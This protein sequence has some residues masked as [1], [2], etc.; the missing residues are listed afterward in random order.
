MSTTPQDLESLRRRLY[1]SY[2]SDH[3]GEGDTALE[4]AW[5]QR[6]VHP[7]MPADRQS[8]VID[9]GCGQ[10]AAV[11]SLADI[12]YVNA[13]GIDRS[14]EQ[15]ELARAAG[16]VN[17]HHGDFR[18]FI[19]RQT[20]SLDGVL[21]LDLLEHLTKDEVLETF[22]A[23]RAAL[24]PGGVFVARVPNAASPFGGRI[25]YGD[26]THESS[27]TARSLRQLC[28][29][30]DLGL[31]QVYDSAPI[32]GDVRGLLRARAWPILAAAMRVA[33]AIESGRG[34]DNYVAQNIVMVTYRP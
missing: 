32:S 3:A 10:G 15:V 11:R 9:I 25:R 16:T 20:G 30:T 4:S 12:G 17:V 7:F 1:A 6:Y 22:D 23:V 24:R 33:L 27:F 31:P 14:P 19:G 8:N 2:A 13:S 5:C 29:V 26:F 34:G 28:L 18:H 21:A